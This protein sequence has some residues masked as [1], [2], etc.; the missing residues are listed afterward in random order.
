MAYRLPPL[1]A[2]RMFEAAAR[3]LSFK[4]AASE[5]H[6]TPAAVS[7][8]VKAL[9]DYLGIQLFRRFVRALELTDEAR[10][11]LPKITE[12]FDCLAAAVEHIRKETAGGSL[13]VSTP[14]SFATRWLV[15]RLQAFAAAHPAIDLRIDTDMRTIDSRNEEAVA[16]AEG[17]LADVTI[18]FGSG[19][20]PGYRVDKLFAVSY[21]AV[22]SPRLLTGKHPL[23]VPADL[24][25]HT[26][27]HDD[28]IP[29]LMVR[30]SWEEWLKVAG[31]TVVDPSR[32]PH[33]NNSVLTL[34]AALD[35]LG[36]ALGMLP[37]VGPDLAAGRLV[38]PFD[39]RKQSNFAYYLVCT[40]SVADR[41]NVVAFREW[42][43]AQAAEDAQS[44]GGPPQDHAPT[45]PQPP[46]A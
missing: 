14:P 33:F 3:H 32:G 37:L 2:L 20:Y 29:D 18:R 42:L 23:R 19:M 34:A 22:C 17:D 7:H 31:V 27:L 1:N 12:G 30:P 45:P 36:V 8:Q 44:A 25:H 41:P 10:A 35:G 11:A 15:P 43:L 5:L 13:T 4:K 39:V 24:R 6:V 16:G 46:P 26:L 40:E 21:V 9:E 28:T 38:A